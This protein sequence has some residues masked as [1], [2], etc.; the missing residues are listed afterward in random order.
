MTAVEKHIS[1]DL[2]VEVLEAKP[3]SSTL[4]GFCLHIS[5]CRRSL[6]AMHESQTS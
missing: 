6:A 5:V 3:S 1:Q 2:T 4:L